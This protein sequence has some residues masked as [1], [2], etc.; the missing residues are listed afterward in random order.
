MSYSSGEE[1]DYSSED[2]K[3]YN[4]PNNRLIKRYNPPNNKLINAIRNGDVEIIQKLTDDGVEIKPSEFSEAVRLGNLDVIRALLYNGAIISFNDLLFAVGRGLEE[5]IKEFID[6]G[7]D[8][9]GNEDLDVGKA[10]EATVYINEQYK[11][12]NILEMLLSA[13]A[14]DPE[15][16]AL[17]LH[18]VHSDNE[19][20]GILLEHLN[21][22][23]IQVKIAI[24]EAV[25]Y[26]KLHNAFEL[27][28]YL[29]NDNIINN[30][31]NNREF[32]LNQNN[33]R[34]A[35]RHERPNIA[36]RIAVMMRSF[37]LVRH[38]VDDLGYEVGP[39]AIELALLAGRLGDPDIE[40]Y[41]LSN[42]VLL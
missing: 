7:I 13:G 14:I 10:L 39:E 18:A 17:E 41:I 38:L 2:E 36:L 33:F 42:I 35:I 29:N 27:A 5:V 28:L 4:P 15:G 6:S 1:K 34:A 22:K 9:N 21:Y 23:P 8:V 30:I 31:L 26:G 3:E 19:S 20:I 24:D 16:T 32:N 12:L 40:E 37:A 11:R 25:S